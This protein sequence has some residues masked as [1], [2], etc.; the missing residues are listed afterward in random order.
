[1]D[2]HLVLG[3]R[4]LGLTH[5]VPHL[6]NRIC[7][8]VWLPLPSATILKGGPCCRPW[9]APGA[10]GGTCDLVSEGLDKDVFHSL[11]AE[12]TWLGMLFNVTT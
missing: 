2:D 12:K 9:F 3:C 5:F 1:M 4:C 10:Y 11:Y 8:C 6:L 7:Q